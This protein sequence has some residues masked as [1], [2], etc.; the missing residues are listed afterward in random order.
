MIYSETEKLAPDIT[1]TI[2]TPATNTILV[3]CPLPY[4]PTNGTRVH[5]W[6]LIL[7]FKQTG[8]R[9]VVAAYNWPGQRIFKA[10]G[11][12]GI[13]LPIDI[14][15]HLFERSFRYSVAKDPHTA[16]NLHKLQTLIDDCKPQVVWC[17]YSDLVPLVSQLD[18]KGAHLW[19]RPHDFELAHN[20]E[21]AIASRPWK[22][23]WNQNTFKQTVKWSKKLL[24]QT[25]QSFASERQMH[26]I[27]DRIF[28]N[29]YSDMQFMSR[30]YG[31]TV[32]KD[33]VVPFLERERIPVKDNKSP[34]DVVYISSNYVSP[35]HLSG[36]RQLL[37]RVIPAVEQAMPGQFRFH[38]VGKGCAEHLS[39][40]ASNA[41]VIHDFVD[42]LSAFM[43]DN[44]D[45]ACLPVEIGWGCKIK[46][47]EAMASGLP[48]IGLPQTFRG[49]PPTPG[50]YYACHSTQEFVSAFRAL[51]DTNTRRQAA[52]AGLTTYTAW[53][54][55]GRQIL[56][57]ALNQLTGSREQ[58]RAGSRE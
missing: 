7:F 12:P 16:Q 33:W 32:R 18:L 44:I 53:R 15:F 24:Q 28:F 23:G 50:A 57:E 49:V 51:Q 30:L 9:V 22:T 14:E 36:V 26:R 1:N 40:Y 21:T 37:Q 34:L 38:F 58:G 25:T 13:D 11:E 39:Q 10:D 46:V 35:T 47:L 31:G 3:I 43:R 19:F 20:I 55:E 42:D 8:W 41:I 4:P 6:G 48:V 52:S 5:I 2:T 54:N 45:I 29:A 27:S 17:N 56:S